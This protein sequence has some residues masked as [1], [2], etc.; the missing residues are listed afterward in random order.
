MANAEIDRI[1]SGPDHGREWSKETSGIASQQAPETCQ[2]T[3]LIQS[4][5]KRPAQ[6]IYF[7][8]QDELDLKAGHGA[9]DEDMETM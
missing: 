1:L 7:N 9:E 4:S 6:A 3:P 5:L 2:E 8:Y